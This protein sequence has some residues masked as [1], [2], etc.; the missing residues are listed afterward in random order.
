MWHRHDSLHVTPAYYISTDVTPSYYIST[1]V[2]PSYYINT[3]V[4]PLYFMV[5]LHKNYYA[6][7]LFTQKDTPIDQS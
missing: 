7:D 5:Y 3:Y 1:Y 4:T 2:T 6:D